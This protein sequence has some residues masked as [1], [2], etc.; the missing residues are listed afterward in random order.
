MQISAALQASHRWALNRVRGVIRRSFS[1]RDT[2]LPHLAA[3]QVVELPGAE[4]PLE[5][6]L[7][8]PAAVAG[9]APVL[10]YFHGGGFVMNDLDT[11]EPLCIRLAVA[12]GM[13]VLASSYRLA[14]EHRFPAQI[15]DA[16]CVAQ[17]LV[18]EGARV[19]ETEGR[20]AIG[21]DSAGGYLAAAA[22]AALAAEESSTV[23]AQ[24]LLYPLLHLDE[25]L[26][27]QSALSQ[28]RLLGWGAVRYINRQ[29]QGAV[30]E[31]PSFL[32]AGAVA[33]APCV[34]VAGGTLDP[35][36]ADA[37]R[38]AVSLKAADREVVWQE[39]PMLMHGFGHLAHVSV[40]ARRAVEKAGRAVGELA[41]RS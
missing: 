3:V 13:R 29:L 30:A 21:G 33:P 20:I 4:G 27:R 17:F 38:L 32:D 40:T 5:A 1:S 31:P 28:T 18:G 9:D 36:R 24:M 8:T 15:D 37:E 14:P 22:A 19:F 26:W 2:S 41:W 35:C 11:H 25:A 10:L 12:A 23:R 7:Y 16:K 6:R 39:N 34:I